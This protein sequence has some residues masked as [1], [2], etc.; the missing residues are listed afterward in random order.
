[1]TSTARRTYLPDGDSSRKYYSS[2]GCDKIRC[3]DVNEFRNVAKCAADIDTSILDDPRPCNV[4]L[5]ELL[6]GAATSSCIHE[7]GRV[8][9]SE[10]MCPPQL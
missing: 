8:S 6:T 5:I 1:M 10:R 3:A 4:N 2:R 9:S 7:R